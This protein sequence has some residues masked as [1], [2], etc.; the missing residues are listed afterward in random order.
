MSNVKPHFSLIKRAGDFVFVSGQMPFDASG[1]IVGTDIAAQVDQCLDNI[2]AALQ[3]VG[4]EFRHVVKTMVWLTKTE[5]FPAFNA[6]YAARFPEAPPA[7]AT[8]CSALMVPGALV[9][10]EAI[11]YDGE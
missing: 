4:C 11:A 5:D 3:T 8:V 9:E 7:R 2:N 10:I 1:A 6:A